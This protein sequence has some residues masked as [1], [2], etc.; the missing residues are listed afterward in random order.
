MYGRNEIVKRSAVNKMKQ[1]DFSDRRD[2]ASKKVCMC[3]GRCGELDRCDGKKPK[4]ERE[5]KRNNCTLDRAK[6][7]NRKYRE[8]K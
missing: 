2:D 3:L 4:R 1:R 5:R 6:S 8:P 7:K